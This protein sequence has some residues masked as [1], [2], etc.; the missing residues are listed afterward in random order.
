MSQTG[1]DDLFEIP[2]DGFHRFA[3]PRT[4]GR[5]LICDFARPNLRENGIALRVPL[6]IGKPID[7]RVAHSAEFIGGHN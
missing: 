4:A 2:Q 6:I 1:D 3:L 5:Q 7:Y